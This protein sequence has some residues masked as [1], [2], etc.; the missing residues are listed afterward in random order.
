MEQVTI[1]KVEFEKL[2]KKAEIADDALIQ[3]K[4]SLEDMKNGKISRF[5]ETS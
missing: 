2:K 5:L 4:L 3:L 1:S